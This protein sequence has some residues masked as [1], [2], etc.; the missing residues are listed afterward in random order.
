MC[1][2]GT[3]DLPDTFVFEQIGDTF[4]LTTTANGKSAL[5]CLD[6]PSAIKLILSEFEEMG[7]TEAPIAGLLRELDDVR[8]GGLAFDESEHAEDICA[9]GFPI[10]D[11]NGD[12]LALSVPVPSSR[13]ARTKRDLQ[14]VMV[15][16]RQELAA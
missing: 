3:E 1:A 5:S 16:A 10:K 8:N 15:E 12:I 11:T 6:Q 14:K 13:Y 2:A 9:V 4:P 7:R